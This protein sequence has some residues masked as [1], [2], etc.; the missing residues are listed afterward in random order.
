MNK[1]LEYGKWYHIRNHYL[2]QGTYLDVNGGARS[3]GN[4]MDVSANFLN[5]RIGQLTGTW[6]LIYS[7]GEQRTDSFVHDKD[8]FY[9]QN[10]HGAGGYL[11]M[12]GSLPAARTIL[13]MCK[14][15]L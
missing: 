8:I 9:V 13:P 5:D 14:H 2:P 11:D 4:Y 7:S 1:P 10:M 12:G 15:P 6:R 3:S